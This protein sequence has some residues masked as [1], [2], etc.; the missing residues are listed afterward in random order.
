MP[1][2]LDD[3][4]L[5]ARLN[6]LGEHP[7]PVT[8]KWVRPLSTAAD[9]FIDWLTTDEE[10]FH[11][12]IRPVDAMVRGIGRGEM[13]YITGKSHS[14]KT[15]FLIQA[16]SNNAGRPMIWFTPDEVDVLVLAKLIAVH[17]GIR[18]DELEQRIKSGDQDAI[19]L[20][21]EVVDESFPQL[22]IVDETLTLEEMSMA[23]AE[24]RLMWGGA[25][26]AVAVIDFL[27]LL[28]GHGETS[29]VRQ[30]SQ[31]VK[32][33]GKQEDVPVLCIHQAKRGDGQ[34]GIA[35]GIEGMNYSG[36][37]EAN[38]VLEVFRKRDGFNPSVAADKQNWQREQNT[39]T[40][41][42]CKNK[43]PP[44]HKGMVDLFLEPTCG[45]IRPLA[46]AP[47]Q[48]PFDTKEEPF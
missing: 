42:V 16:I 18:A 29:G 20:V 33:W 39:V 40:V 24:A 5:D 10:R 25:E 17:R 1:E 46:E 37:T 9:Q 41:N 13:A 15:Q 26:P 38:Y 35:Q 7:E 31:D 27:E 11:F 12:G 21:Y 8:Y 30:K 2:L 44:C 3:D 47:P 48:T 23:L 43:R 22:A 36:E 28:P 34:R 45:Q 32:R 19:A 6:S 14:G 4:D